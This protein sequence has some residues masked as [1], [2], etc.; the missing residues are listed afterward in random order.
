LYNYEIA[1]R[2]H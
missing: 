1:D 2:I